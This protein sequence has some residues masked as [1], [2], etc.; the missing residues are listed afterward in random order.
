MVVGGRRLVEEDFVGEVE[1]RFSV[2]FVSLIF[3][4][5]FLFFFHRSDYHCTYTALHCSCP[6]D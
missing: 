5:H 1:K 4:L 2:V 6:I 3:T